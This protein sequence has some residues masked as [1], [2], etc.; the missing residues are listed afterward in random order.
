MLKDHLFSSPSAAG[1]FLLGGTNNG[2]TSWKNGAGVELKDIEASELSA[3]SG[4]T[5]QA[6]DEADAPVD[7]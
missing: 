6:G 7:Q 4:L 2:R 5:V 1:G 3:A